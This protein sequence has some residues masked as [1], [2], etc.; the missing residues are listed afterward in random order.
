M[1]VDLKPRIYVAGPYRGKTQRDVDLNIQKAENLGLVIFNMGAVPVI[2]HSMYRSYKDLP[3]DLVIE[4]T[5][6]LLHTCQAMVVDLPHDQVIDSIGTMGEIEDCRQNKRSYFY[7]DVSVDNNLDALKFWIGEYQ[8]HIR[9]I[10]NS[11]SSL[12]GKF[13]V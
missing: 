12:Y 1:I 5:L 13:G 4:A 3:D 6:S 9:K 10:I 8:P 2:P 11:Y 7:D